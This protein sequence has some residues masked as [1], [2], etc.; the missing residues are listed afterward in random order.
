MITHAVK[1]EI[2][3][4]ML[5]IPGKMES[6]LPLKRTSVNGQ[7]QGPICT[8]GVSQHFENP[9]DEAAE[10]EYLF[11]LPHKA[12]IINFEIQIGKRKIKGELQE[13]EQA[14]VTYE[15]ARE[16]GHLSGL[17]EERRPNLFAVHIA[18]ILPNETI[19][20][21]IY[22]QERLNFIDG[23][24]EFIFPMGLTPKYHSPEHPGEA[25][26]INA[27]VAGDDD[28]IGVVEISISVDAGSQTSEPTSVSH[29][30]EVATLDER[31]FIVQLASETIPNKDFILHY[32]LSSDEIALSTWRAKGQ[33][34]DYF[35]ATITP[36]AM[37]ETEYSTPPREF[38]FV[39][40]RSGSM[41]GGPIAQAR[42]A[43]SACLRSLN[44][45]DNFRILLFDH[46]LE[47]FKLEPC[48]VSQQA[49]D[50]ADKFISGIEGRGGTEIVSAIK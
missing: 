16:Q 2:K 9:L 30:I 5:I 35:L 1:E 32:R 38:I 7:I 18:N 50:E 33:D 47:W 42:N 46:E 19:K 22:Y 31:R 13:I 27:P 10:L 3:F 6:S 41:T 34:A 29:P 48:S 44:E 26:G 39:L 23:E 43:L 37:K 25:A 49:I 36:P 24:Y 11:P 28:P 45:D 4:G 15:Q 20:T 14:R 40:D 8:V 21:T 12:S 17:L